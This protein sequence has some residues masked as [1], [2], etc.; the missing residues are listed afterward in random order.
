MVDGAVV[1]AAAVVAVQGVLMK[2]TLVL[3]PYA[4]WVYS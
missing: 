4:H 1:D 2:P 3:V